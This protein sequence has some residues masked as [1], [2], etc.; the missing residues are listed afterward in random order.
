MCSRVRENNMAVERTNQA[1][2]RFTSKTG[3][4]FGVILGVFLFVCASLAYGQAGLGHRPPLN[5][6]VIRR[7]EKRRWPR[8]DMARRR[9]PTS[10]LLDWNPSLPK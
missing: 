5:P 3:N 8:P 10:N 4:L 9:R 1:V 7:K 2:H 6:S